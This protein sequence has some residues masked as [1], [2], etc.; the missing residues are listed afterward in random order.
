MQ[1]RGR[2]TL[3]TTYAHKL[4]K[5][6]TCCST[7]NIKFY[8]VSYVPLL[9]SSFCWVWFCTTRGPFFVAEDIWGM[10][11]VPKPNGTKK[12]DL[13]YLA[14]IVKL[15]VGFRQE[16]PQLPLGVSQTKSKL[17][18]GL[19]WF[20]TKNSPP[21][22]DLRGRNSPGGFQKNIKHCSECKR[23]IAPFKSREHARRLEKTTE[24]N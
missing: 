24:N 18:Q 9:V 21:K 4:W 20:S 3:L 5:N 14:S 17:P 23:I 10:C 6:R 12:E 8:S 16:K 13:Q 11:D 7:I 22:S 2:N 1:K 15:R 19:S